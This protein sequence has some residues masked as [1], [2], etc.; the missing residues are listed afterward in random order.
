MSYSLRSF[1]M[2]LSDGGLVLDAS[3]PVES[4]GLDQLTRDESI[5]VESIETVV[6]RRDEKTPVESEGLDQLNR[7]ESI[8]IDALLGGVPRTQDAAIPIDSTGVEPNRLL[9]IWS[10][11]QPLN[12]PFTLRWNVVQRGLIAQLQLRWTV[13]QNIVPF[14]L[15]WNVV[16]NLLTPLIENDV[17]KPFGVITKTP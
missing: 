7:D 11:R 4:E 13:R 12:T 10:V 3:I 1:A 9:L 16:P 2:F 17:Q 6:L 14:T 5:P 8:P 15:R